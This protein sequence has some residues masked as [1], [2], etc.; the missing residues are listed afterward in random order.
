M[1]FDFHYL[2]SALAQV[3]PVF[4]SE[5][6]FQHALAWQIQQT[7]PQASIRLE[8]PVRASGSK[9]VH[10]DLLVYCDQQR[11]AIELKYKTAALL[12]NASGEQ[13]SLAG[14]S[15]Q[16]TG[17]YDFLKD[18]M[19]LEQYVASNADAVGYA[20]LLSNDG[21]YWGDSQRPRTSTQFSIHEERVITGQ[22]HWEAHASA[23]SK[24]GREAPI[25]C[26][27]SYTC[28]WND[29]SQVDGTGA[30]QFKYLLLTVQR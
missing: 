11:H 25:Q 29:Y 12:A 15:A 7:N 18:I 27:S 5:A 1:A 6:D 20:V 17:R 30:K 24:K 3:R 26:R 13:Y 22:L 16:D 14:Q 19:R 10:L 2:L 23:G 28:T 8:L 9:T 21:L 4:H